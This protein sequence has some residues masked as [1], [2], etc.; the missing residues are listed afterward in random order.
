MFSLAKLLVG[1]VAI[2]SANDKV[3]FLIDIVVMGVEVLVVVVVKYTW[4]S[5]VLHHDLNVGL[6][7]SWGYN[8]LSMG[9]VAD[10]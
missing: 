8:L 2:F 4:G 6:D 9:L 1:V 7:V 3:S 5:V 10:W